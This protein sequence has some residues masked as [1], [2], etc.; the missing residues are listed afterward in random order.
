ML[1]LNLIPPLVRTA[2]SMLLIGGLIGYVG[3]AFT[4]TL[5]ADSGLA[6]GLGESTAAHKY[7]MAFVKRES[8]NI[9]R[10]GP[11][12]DVVT[13]ALQQQNVSQQQQSDDVKALSVTYLGGQSS[14]RISVQIYAVEL[15]GRGGRYQFFPMALT[16][17]SGQVQR[18]E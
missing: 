2:I 10:L 4:T 13:R 5:I 16:L 1:G 3:T 6:G 12:T 7:V 8:E 17:V 11:T 18:V 9:S 15:Q 14:G